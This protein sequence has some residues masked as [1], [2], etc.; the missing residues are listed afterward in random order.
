M[1]LTNILIEGVTGDEKT[2]RGGPLIYCQ[3]L[4]PFFIT[5][6]EMRENRRPWPVLAGRDNRQ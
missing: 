6:S 2:L 5:F 1:I 3:F 4:P